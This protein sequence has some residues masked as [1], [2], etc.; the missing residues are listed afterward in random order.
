MDGLIPSVDVFDVLLFHLVRLAQHGKL[1]LAAFTMPAAH[2]IR[3]QCCVLLSSSSA[4]I[5]ERTGLLC[6]SFPTIAKATVF[7]EAGRNRLRAASVDRLRRRERERERDPFIITR[8]RER[9][10]PVVCEETLFP[11]I[12]DEFGGSRDLDFEEDVESHQFFSEHI[13]R[14]RK[15]SRGRNLVSGGD[16]ELA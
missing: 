9:G 3:I 4:R 13:Y 14:E 5:L 15:P 2:G 1:W 11:S 7:A 10:R 16:E 12:A 8:I 6:S